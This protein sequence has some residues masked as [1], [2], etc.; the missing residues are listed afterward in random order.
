MNTVGD[1]LKVLRKEK[2]WTQTKIAEKL[3]LSV[4]A[5]AKIESGFTTMTM[6]RVHEFV[7]LF[8]VPVHVILCIEVKNEEVENV[9]ILE[10]LKT[11]LAGIDTALNKLR[12]TAIELYEILGEKG[13]F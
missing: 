12:V 5:Y 10:G 11:K 3:N 2:R 7:S 6:S 4:P 9:I 1:N 8:D 13:S